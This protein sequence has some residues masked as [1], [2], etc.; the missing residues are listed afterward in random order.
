MRFLLYF[1]ILLNLVLCGCLGWRLGALSVRKPVPGSE[2][3]SN[4]GWKEVHPVGIPHSDRGSSEVGELGRGA[5]RDEMVSVALD[6]RNIESSDYRVY[7]QR[8]RKAG[9]PEEI[10]RELVVADVRKAFAP[11]AHAILG[12]NGPAR[13]WQ[14]PQYDP[15]TPEQLDQLTALES[16]EQSVLSEI[17]VVGPM[18]QRLVDRLYLQVD[19]REVALEFLPAGTRDAAKRELEEAGVRHHEMNDPSVAGGGNDPNGMDRFQKRLDVL[20]GLLTKEEL[21]S[22]RARIAPVS[23]E[24]ANRLQGIELSEQEFVRVVG[25]RLNMPGGQGEG[26]SMSE[27]KVVSE[28][29]GDERAAQYFKRLDDTYHY[30]REAVQRYGLPAG[31]AEEVYALKEASQQEAKRIRATGGTEQEKRLELQSL[32]SGTERQMREKLGDQGFGLVSRIGAWLQL[33]ETPGT[34][35]P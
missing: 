33:L 23:Q 25:V 3:S 27:L 8:L 20:S 6:W 21:E 14:K 26:H 10:V 35:T 4:A 5:A 19:P 17:L 16:E 11:R 24:L 18:V 29:L 2:V 31:V 34:S 32:R 22:Y 9:V 1:S 15:P 12:T 30:A 28:I 7:V 13:Y